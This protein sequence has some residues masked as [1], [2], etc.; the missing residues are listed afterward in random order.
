MSA[1]PSLFQCFDREFWKDLQTSISFMVR[2]LVL[3]KHIKMSRI[4]SE[5]K[6][7][8][9]Y[10]CSEPLI[11]AWGDPDDD[12]LPSLKAFLLL[13]KI[14]ENCEPLDQI[15]QACGKRSLP[16]TVYD[17]LKEVFRS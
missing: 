4:V 16:E 10:R 12:R 2:D 17:A 5:L 15:N 13:I 3:G 9:V 6:R 11:Y 1:Q 14:T 7:A 8:G